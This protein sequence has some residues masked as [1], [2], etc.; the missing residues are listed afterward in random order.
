MQLSR[1]EAEFAAFRATADGERAALE[2]ARAAAA[3]EAAALQE[4]LAAQQAEVSK[5]PEG[6]PKVGCCALLLDA[7]VASLRLLACHALQR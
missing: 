2:A 4:Q 5:P 7:S 6:T 3:A 1:L